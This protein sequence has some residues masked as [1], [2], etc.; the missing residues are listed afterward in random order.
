MA[1]VDQSTAFGYGTQLT[2]TQM[3]NLRDNLDATM[4]KDEGAPVL[5]NNYIV[6]DMITDGEVTQDKLGAASVSQSKLDTDTEEL[7]HDITDEGTYLFTLTSPGEYGFFPQTKWEAGVG[8]K[9]CYYGGGS[10][11]SGG[12]S[13]TSEISMSHISGSDKYGYVQTRY[14]TSSGNIGWLFLLADKNTK[15]I[16][17]SSFSFDHPCWGRGGDPSEYPHPFVNDYDPNKHIIYSVILTREE[18]KSIK[19][20]DRKKGFLQQINESYSIDEENPTVWPENELPVKLIEEDP[21]IGKISKYL[22]KKIPKPPYIKMAR[23]I[24]K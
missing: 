7:S 2:S 19:N 12:T 11:N 8:T 21:K 1:Y 10:A 13:Y 9:F 5:A 24:K 16:I 6:E 18:H 20:E 14:V 23:L 17:G 4:A 3:Q 22:N 15:K